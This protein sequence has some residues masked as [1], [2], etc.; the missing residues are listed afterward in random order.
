MGA[1]I[2]S[3]LEIKELRSRTKGTVPREKFQMFSDSNTAENFG[4]KYCAPS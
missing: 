4:T 1:V 3:L 2:I